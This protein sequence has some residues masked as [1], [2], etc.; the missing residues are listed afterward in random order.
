M[1]IP[2]DAVLHLCLGAA[3]RD[4]TRWADPDSFDLFR[5]LQRSVSFAAGAHS[6]LGQHVSRQEMVVAL[7]GL[8]ERFP[9]LRWDP[10]QPPATL[11]GGM[12]ARG[13]GRLPVLLH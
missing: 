11:S 8:F 2:K 13:P 3:N 1:D 9:N 4:P 5:P 12:L 7:G 10:S 6:C